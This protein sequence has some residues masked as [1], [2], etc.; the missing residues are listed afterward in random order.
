MLEGPELRR[1]KDMTT[2]VN[3]RLA[4][5]PIGV[6]RLDVV[7]P[8]QFFGSRSKPTPEQRLMLAVLQ[9]ALDCIQKHRD[10]RLFDEARHWFLAD[11]TDWPYSFERICAAL[12]L[13]ANA[14]RQRL[15]CT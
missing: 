2:E 11:E 15:P 8:S 12:D 13:D 4:G 5:L 9:D 6:A 3:P 7:L 14:V 1:G 10:R